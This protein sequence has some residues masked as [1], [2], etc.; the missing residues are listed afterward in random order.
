MKLKGILI[1]LFV[2][3]LT[4]CSS[5]SDNEKDLSIRLEEKG[6][7]NL[8]HSLFSAVAEGDIEAMLE[9]LEAGA[10]INATDTNGNTVVMTAT[11]KNNVDTVKILIEQGADINIRNDN[12]DNVLLYSGAEGLL[13][14]V[15][16]AI[17]AGADTT[18]TNRF[19][20]IALIPASDRGHVDIVEELLLN[21]DTDVNHLNNLHWTAL[22]EAIILGGGGGNYQQIVQLLVNHGADVNISDRDGITPL[23][24]AK[25]RGFQEIERILKEVGA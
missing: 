8:N 25:Q 2:G 13:E 21:S 7:G 5:I 14:I 18:L 4:A 16:L 12:Q 9:L 6:E 1:S 24:H 20:G 19:G 10:D 17:E 15:Q 22:L 11:Q 3:I 23:E